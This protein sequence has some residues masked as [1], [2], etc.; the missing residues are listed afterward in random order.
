MGGVWVANLVALLGAGLAGAGWSLLAGHLAL[1]NGMVHGI[2]A[3]ARREYNPGLI[4]GLALL[5]PDGAAVIVAVSAEPGVG[6]AAHLQA[7][8]A[9]LLLHGAIIAHVKRRS[10]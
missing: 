2:A 3:L 1:V 6:T 5:I 10:R 9:I 4:T 8:G 7:L